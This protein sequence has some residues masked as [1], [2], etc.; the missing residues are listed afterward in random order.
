MCSWEGLLDFKNEDYVGFYLLSRQGS[1]SPS[2]YFRVSVG[3][4]WTPAP[5][6]GAYLLSISCLN[7]ITGQMK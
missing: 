5:Q 6:P 4:G 3:K 7:I 1:A 2:C